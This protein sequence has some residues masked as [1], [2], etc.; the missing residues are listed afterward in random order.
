MKKILLFIATW[1]LVTTA[2]SISN[3]ANADGNSRSPHIDSKLEFPNTKWAKVRQTIQI[4]VPKTS[5]AL[6]K[7]WIDIPQQFEFQ[8]AKIE[9]TDGERPISALISRQ[10]RWLQINFSQPLAPDTKLRIDFNGVNRNML[11]QQPVYYVYANTL[12]GV[13][14]FIGEAYFP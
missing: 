11:A 1:S 5:S 8:T 14:N 7:L 9:I 2:L 10:D 4:H 13:T 3:Y 6:T 12:S